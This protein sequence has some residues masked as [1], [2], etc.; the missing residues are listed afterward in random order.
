ML[1]SRSRGGDVSI[2]DEI[3]VCQSE[4]GGTTEGGCWGAS[5]NRAEEKIL[6]CSAGRRCGGIGVV[7]SGGCQYTS[8]SIAEGYWTAL[9]YY[10]KHRQKI[11]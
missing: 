8:A 1:H 11:N 6:G 7:A 3:L 2:C 4:M 9:Q 5:H 10:G